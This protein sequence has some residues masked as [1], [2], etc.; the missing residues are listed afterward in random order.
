VLVTTEK[1]SDAL[2][3]IQQRY[4]W[5]TVYY[6]HHVFAAQ[7]WYR[8][9][10]YD[11]RIIAPKNRHLDKHYISLNRI[12]SNRRVY[13][14]LLV[15][16]LIKHGVLNQ[17]Y[18]SFSRVCPE[19]GAFQDHLLSAAEHGWCNLSQAQEAIANIDG[20]DCNF[21][22]DHNDAEF[23]PNQSFV[24]GAESFTQRSFC[25]VVT[26]TCFWERKCHLTE[27]I[28]KPIVSKMPFILVGAAHNLAYLKSYGFK[29]FDA[30]WDESYDDI[31]DPMERLS[32]IGQLLKTICQY[33]LADLEKLLIEM[34]PVLEH[35]FKLFNSSEFVDS[36][37]RELT[38][39]L[40]ESV[41]DFIPIDYRIPPTDFELFFW[42]KVQH[43]E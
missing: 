10:R 34:T 5:P 38:T 41:S 17:G 23:I 9:H 20:V 42:P 39:S 40:Q 21:R 18:V 2:D 15:N 25:F 43:P 28:F 37:W 36:V 7:D 14:S 6:F 33:S 8:G 19:G 24:I 29:T 16:E 4:D 22:V 3:A 1:H 13:R 35:N 32:A 31:T 30:W 12:T 26:E 27:K 11:A